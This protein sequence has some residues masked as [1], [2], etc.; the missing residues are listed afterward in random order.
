M[1]RLIPS[2]LLVCAGCPLTASLGG[3]AVEVSTT[4]GP[5]TDPSSTSTSSS[6]SSV[7]G[8][9]DD[10]GGGSFGGSGDVTGSMTE[11]STSTGEGAQTTAEM[12][13]ACEG[14]IDGSCVSCL[15]VNCC[16]ALAQCLGTPLC[17]CLL[18]CLEFAPDFLSC[19][20]I[21]LCEGGPM[22]SELQ[23]CAATACA[24]SCGF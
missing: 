7:S 19:V 22:A 2:L 14:T 11:G 10:S 8:S 24:G 21:P 3:D 15:R 18:G 23:V 13:N 20:D 17:A 16:S 12:P 9:T 4:S 6:T 1:R 5:D